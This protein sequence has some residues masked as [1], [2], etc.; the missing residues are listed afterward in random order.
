MPQTN[1]RTQMPQFDLFTSGV[2]PETV[3]GN[4]KPE[5]ERF[6]ILINSMTRSGKITQLI[7]HV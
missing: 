3:S 7:K 4:I 1:A 2:F 6:L 5:M